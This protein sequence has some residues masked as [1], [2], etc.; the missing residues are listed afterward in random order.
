VAEF[1]AFIFT[2]Q[3]GP[4]ISAEALNMAG[5]DRAGAPEIQTPN[6]R[7]LLKSWGIRCFTH[8]Y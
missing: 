3:K 8:F 6:T 4:S 7:L 5:V 1:F 2:K